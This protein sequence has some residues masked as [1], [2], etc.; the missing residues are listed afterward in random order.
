MH[1]ACSPTVRGIGREKQRFR[2]DKAIRRVAS[3]ADG[4]QGGRIRGLLF[5]P[6][7]GPSGSVAGRPAAPTPA[8]SDEEQHL[9]YGVQFDIASQRVRGLFNAAQHKFGLKASQGRTIQHVLNQ[10]HCLKV[11]DASSSG[12]TSVSSSDPVIIRG[13]VIRY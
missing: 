6:I 12:S 4:L 3:V 11:I 8:M 2:Q 7:A 10:R 13:M 5:P 1:V 9:V